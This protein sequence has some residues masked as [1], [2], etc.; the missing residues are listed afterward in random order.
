MTELEKIEYA[1][2]F[3]DK[4]ANGINP[5]DDTP[6][7]DDDA[8][9]N[10]RLSRC[11]FFV[12]DVLRQV[13][14]N[15]GITPPVKLARSIPFEISSEQLKKFEF[16]EFPISIS[17]IAKRVSVLKEDDNMKNI[18]HKDLTSWLLATNI[19]CEK[20]DTATGK[21]TKYPTPQ[22]LEFGISQELRTGPSG[23][24][25]ATLYNRSA[26]EFIIDNFEAIL[27]FKYKK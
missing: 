19:L 5:I 18:S 3:I 11:F 24:Y 10:V 21:K 2:S 25:K 16:S 17:E 8:I 23:E 13:I 26:Q 1:K 20:E 22:G 6:V 12:S 14:E 7:K 27:A 15:G 9:N 4:L